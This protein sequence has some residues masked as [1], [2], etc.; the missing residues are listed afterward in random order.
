MSLPTRN[1]NWP[2][3]GVGSLLSNFFDDDRFFNSPWLRGQNMPAVNVKET[4]SAYEIELAAPGFQKSDFNVAIE[5]GILTISCE[6]KSQS[7]KSE[8][9]YTRK[10]FEYSSFSRS[11]NL[12]ENVSDDDV[13]AHYENGVLKLTVSKK[14]E[15]TKPKKAIDIK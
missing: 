3:L 15:A 14:K 10:E 1:S 4:E 13:E 8:E 9:T 5:N 6:K 11:F 7:E 12:P 2:T